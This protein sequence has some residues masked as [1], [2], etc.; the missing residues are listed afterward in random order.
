MAYYESAQGLSEYLLF[1]YGAADDIL[2]V[3]FGPRDALHYP[4]RAVEALLDLPLAPDARA[5]DLGCAVGRSTFELARH[6]REVVGI[7]F[8]TAFVQAADQL[9]RDGRLDYAFVVEGDLRQP[10]IATVPADID[11]TRATFRHGD[12]TALPEDLGLFDVIFMAN[13]IDRLHRP[14][15]C[16]ASLARHLRPGGQ[17]LITSPYTWMETYTPKAEWLGGVERDGKP[18]TTLDGLSRCL[19]PDFDLEATVELPFLLRE[20]ARKYQWS[21]AQ[22]TRWRRT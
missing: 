10:A 22:G 21:I 7:D 13:L 20:H 19:T 15:A 16:L 12:A 8:S 11:R 6:A 14:A 18:V 3:P 2:P 1:H 4:V 17:L 5:L 9:A